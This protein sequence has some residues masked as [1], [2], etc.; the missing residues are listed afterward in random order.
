MSFFTQH[1]T[2]AEIKVHYR[3]LCMCHHPDREDGDTAVMQLINAE[4]HSALRRCDGQA[5]KGTNNKD[6]TYRYY[7]DIEQ[8]VM[9]K[10][11]E[12]VA[13]GMVNVDIMLIGSWIWI[14]GDTK[15]YA[16]QLGKN[17]LKMLWHP[18]RLAWYWHMKSK[19]KYHFN[20]HV[21][22]DDLAASY[23]YRKFHSAK[24]TSIG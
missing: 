12:I 19:R 21:D 22:L 9:D 23:G 1:S 15:R 13:L 16:K 11:S 10:I 4:Y 5:F 20:S 3:K 17:G 8:A 7:R 24:R 6:H 18:K 2:V 14:T